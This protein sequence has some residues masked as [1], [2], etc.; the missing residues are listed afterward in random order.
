LPEILQKIMNTP[1]TLVI[2]ALVAALGLVGIISV[3]IILTTQEAEASCEKGN[4]GSHAFNQSKGKCFDRGTLSSFED[5]Q[6]VEVEEEEQEEE[7]EEDKEEESSEE[8]DS[9]N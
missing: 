6:N 1:Q 7:V 9:E 8:G 3:N 5:E 2:F 4:A